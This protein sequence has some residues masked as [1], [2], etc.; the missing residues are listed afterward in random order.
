MTNRL[1][2]EVRPE[3]ERLEDRTTPAVGTATL[4]GKTLVIE[5]PANGDDGD[6]GAS[7]INVRVVEK[8][9]KVRVIFTDVAA[10]NAQTIVEFKESRVKTI[11]FRGTTGDD[12]FINRSDARVIANGD[13]GNDLIDTGDEEATVTGGAGADRIISEDDDT[14]V[15]DASA[16]DIIDIDD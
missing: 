2:R 3:L 6:G 9:N 16:E 1:H 10:A 7:P 11:D 15:T 14:E 4:V 13:A 12:V 5:G 8:G